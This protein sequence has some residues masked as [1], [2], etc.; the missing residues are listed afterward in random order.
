MEVVV[1]ELV[2]M[3]ELANGVNNQEL[4]KLSH[5]QHS[6]EKQSHLFGGR[7]IWGSGSSLPMPAARKDEEAGLGEVGRM[8]RSWGRRGLRRAPERRGRWGGS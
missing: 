2:Q 8:E 6:G 5:E 7:R 3:E 4:G 1:D